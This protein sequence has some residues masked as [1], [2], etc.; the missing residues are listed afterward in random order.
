MSLSRPEQ[1]RSP[2]EDILLAA[3]Q[4]FNVDLRDTK[5]VRAKVA[6]LTLS[7]HRT[8]KY[9]MVNRLNDLFEQYSELGLRIK[10]RAA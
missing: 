7:A 3:Q 4:E 9:D 10:K 6:E 1:S 8:G 2:S 5:A